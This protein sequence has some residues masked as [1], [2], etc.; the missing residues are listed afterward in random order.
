MIKQPPDF[1]TALLPAADP[2]S[3]RTGESESRLFRN[4]GLNGMPILRWCFRQQ[5]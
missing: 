4:V 5:R 3:P 1:E 2:P